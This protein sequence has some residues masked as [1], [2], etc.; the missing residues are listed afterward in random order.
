MKVMSR[1]DINVKAVETTMFIIRYFDKDNK[2]S[3]T[4]ISTWKVMRAKLGVTWKFTRN[5]YALCM[6]FLRACHNGRVVT[7]FIIRITGFLPF[8]I[9]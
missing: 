6:R 5:Y 9:M 1:E 7:M 8:H 4:Y 3:I 2:G